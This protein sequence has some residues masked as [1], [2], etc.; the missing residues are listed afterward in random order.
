MRAISRRLLALTTLVAVLA[1]P[2]GRVVIDAGAPEGEI[3][4]EASHDPER[5]RVAHHHRAC[6]QLFASAAAP[7]PVAASPPRPP[8]HPP[9]PG[10]DA[11]RLAPDP[12]PAD[13]RPRAPP[14]RLV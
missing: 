7:S 1:T 13:A 11:G 9:L 3:R 12:I 5:C 6:V 10:L 8:G 14:G 2:V 4:V